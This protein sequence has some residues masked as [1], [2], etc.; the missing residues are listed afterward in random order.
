MFRWQRPHQSLLPW[1][2]G[3]MRNWRTLRSKSFRFVKFG[4]KQNWNCTWFCVYICICSCKKIYP[5]RTLSYCIH[6]CS[7]YMLMYKLTSV[8]VRAKIFIPQGPYC[9]VSMFAHSQFQEFILIIILRPYCCWHRH[10]LCYHLYCRC[11]HHQ[12]CSLIKSQVDAFIS[13]GYKPAS[14]HYNRELLPS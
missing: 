9:I 6:V 7:L 12:H 5:S 13:A 10:H 2:R 1:P 14:V 3:T 4:F 8:F 11:H